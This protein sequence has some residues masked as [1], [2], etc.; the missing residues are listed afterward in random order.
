MIEAFYTLH[1][2]TWHFGQHVILTTEIFNDQP[3]IQKNS[4]LL[5]HGNVREV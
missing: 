4:E 2:A 3:E 5:L 1:S